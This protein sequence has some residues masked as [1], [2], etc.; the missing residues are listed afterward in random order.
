MGKA[1]VYNEFVW[2]EENRFWTLIEATIQLSP[3][4]SLVKVEKAIQTIQLLIR[5]MHKFSGISE[6]CGTVLAS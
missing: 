3:N 1:T 2:C 5:E 6:I 4:F